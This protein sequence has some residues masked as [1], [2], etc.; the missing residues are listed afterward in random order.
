MLRLFLCR[1]GRGDKCLIEDLWG[2]RAVWLWLKPQNSLPEQGNREIPQASSLLVYHE[3]CLTAAGNTVNT[4]D[5]RN[6]EEG[7]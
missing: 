7:G 3:I 2:W 4:V 6:R 5:I 1:R